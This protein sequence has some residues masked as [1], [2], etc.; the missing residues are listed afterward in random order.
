MPEISIDLDEGEFKVVS[1]SFKDES[2]DFVDA[3]H[4]PGLLFTRHVHDI[5]RQ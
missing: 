2:P 3:I 5:Q 1:I 4:H